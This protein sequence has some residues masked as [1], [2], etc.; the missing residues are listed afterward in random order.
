MTGTEMSGFR[1]VGT[2]NLYERDGVFYFRR[3]L[4]SKLRIVV[5]SSEIRKSL[6]TRDL[7][8]ARERCCLAGFALNNALR[9]INAMMTLE[10][11]VAPMLARK[12]LNDQLD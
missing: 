11:D 8:D 1:H 6:R 5:G 10:I 9:K 2:A 12:Y 7:R 4:S 3:Q